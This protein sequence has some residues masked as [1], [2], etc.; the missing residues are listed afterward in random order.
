MSPRAAVPKADIGRAAGLL[1]PI[2]DH[3]ISELI[4]AQVRALIHEG[5]LRPGDRLPPE[6]EMCARFGVSRVA[7]REAL[8]VLEANGLIDVRVGAHGG[9]FVIQPSGDRVRDSIQDL[10]TLSSVT[11]SNVTEVRLVLEEHRAIL[12][13]TRVGDA[14]TGER[15]MR[16]HLNRTAAGVRRD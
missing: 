7:V 6:R 8:R 3:R 16:G 9:A 14:A 2:N 4:I 1:N 13:A 5:R 10:L 11:A 12:A 15:I